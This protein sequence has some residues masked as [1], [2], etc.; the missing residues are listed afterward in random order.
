MYN[1]EA[2]IFDIRPVT[3]GGWTPSLAAWMQMLVR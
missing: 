2:G 3:A 1:R